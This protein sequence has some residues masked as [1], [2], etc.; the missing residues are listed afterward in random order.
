[1]AIWRADDNGNGQI[2]VN[3]VVF[4][5]RCP[6]GDCL[7]FIEFSSVSLPAFSDPNAIL[8]YLFSGTVNPTYTNLIPTCSNVQFVI[9]V[10][11][12]WTRSV[13]VLFDLQENGF[14][15]HYQINATLRA[16]AGHLLN[17]AGLLVPTYDDEQ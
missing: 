13:T 15:N 11:P 6:G 12:P 2:D 17:Q 14:V 10:S 1:L 9:D 7:R 5:S 3:E 8:P 4:L 16:W